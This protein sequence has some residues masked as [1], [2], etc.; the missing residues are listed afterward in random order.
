MNPS[1]VFCRESTRQCTTTS[2]KN[3]FA[4]TRRLGVWDP[5][6]TSVFT[7]S[8][9]SDY[10][11][12]K[13]LKT[14]FKKRRA[15]WITVTIRQMLSINKV[16]FT[17]N[18]SMRPKRFHYYYSSRCPNISERIFFCRFALLSIPPT[19]ADSYKQ[20]LYRS[21]VPNLGYAYP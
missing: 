18:L 19:S 16:N 11:L 7:R 13:H 17:P 15:P 10:K 14:I 6:I 3:D 5:A 12:F 1:D 4:E 8:V 9:P 20:L 21:A 2:R